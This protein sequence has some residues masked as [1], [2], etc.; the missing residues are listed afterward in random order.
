MLSPPWLT[1]THAS[2]PTRTP[3]HL[4]LLHPQINLG[5]SQRISGPSAPPECFLL[6]C[7]LPLVCLPSWIIN[8]GQ[9]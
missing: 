2:V 9:D 1:P 3:P 4:P 6:G 8:Q 7:N 5:A